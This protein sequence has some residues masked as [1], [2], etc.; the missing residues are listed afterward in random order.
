MDERIAERPEYNIAQGYSRGTGRD[1]ARFFEYALGSARESR[2]WYY[3]ARPIL[4]PAATEERLALLTE[5][6]PL[7]L[8][9]I[10]S[11]RGRKIR[12]VSPSYLEGRD[13]TD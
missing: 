1:R 12:E 6:I 9:A 11:Q 5:I 10:P 8:A 2:D 7:L 13:E 3:K 4:G